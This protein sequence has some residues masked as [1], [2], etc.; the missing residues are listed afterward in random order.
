MKSAF[1]TLAIL[2]CSLFANAQSRPQTQILHD[3]ESRYVFDMQTNQYMN[4]VCQAYAPPPIPVPVPPPVNKICELRY[5][6]PGDSCSQYRVYVN[7]AQASECLPL[8]DQALRAM[9]SMRSAGLCVTH[10]AASTCD[11]RFNPP[12]DS[13]GQYRIYIAGKQSS[14]CMGNLNQ[15]ENTVRMFRQANLCY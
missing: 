9:N 7:G 8:L 2:S 6:P 1:L 13:C 12:G 3:G 14:E 11:L 5:N 10:Q 15:A 4:V